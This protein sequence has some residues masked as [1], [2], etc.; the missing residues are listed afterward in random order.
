[1]HTWKHLAAAA[2]LGLSSL[3][4]AAEPTAPID[5]NTASADV[6]AEVIDGVGMKRAQ[7]IIEY[8]EQ[9]GAFASVDD[10]ALVR[11][12]SAGIVERNRDRITANAAE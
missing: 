8:R 9:H 2:A 11:G 7:A 3:T 5:I 1:M 4:F 6:L 12:V 10:L